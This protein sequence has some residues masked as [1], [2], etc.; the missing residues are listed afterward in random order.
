M[1]GISQQETLLTR[2]ISL[3]AKDYYFHYSNGDEVLEEFRLAY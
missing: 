3:N 1:Q 2:S